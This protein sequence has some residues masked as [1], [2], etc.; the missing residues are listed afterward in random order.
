M[1]FHIC[2]EIKIISVFIILAATIEALID[3]L[4]EFQNVVSL[5][6]EAATFLNSLGLYKGGNSSYDRSIILELYNAPSKY[7]RDIKDKKTLIINPR[8]NLCLLGMCK[9]CS[10]LKK[11]YE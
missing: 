5:W 10:F 11:Q 7:R 8:F 1:F 9:M 4:R 6:D 3:R 2:F